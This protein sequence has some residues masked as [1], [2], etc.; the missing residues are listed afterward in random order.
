MKQKSTIVLILITILVTGVLVFNLI[1]NRVPD[2]IGFFG[3]PNDNQKTQVTFDKEGKYVLYLDGK[4]Y[5]HGE[6]EKSTEHAYTLDSSNN[7]D[8]LIILTNKQNFLIIS[9]LQNDPILLD[10]I[11][12]VPTFIE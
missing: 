6:Y 2:I 4:E 8:G 11:S 1:N 10:K 5:D 7:N 9:T 12:D 3:S